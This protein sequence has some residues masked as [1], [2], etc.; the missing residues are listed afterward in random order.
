MAPKFYKKF[1]RKKDLNQ[2]A[3]KNQSRWE[4]CDLF[5]KLIK[6][7]GNQVPRMTLIKTI[8]NQILRMAPFKIPML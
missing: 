7:I 8:G 4:T 5:L 2:N 1:L 3:L 6:T